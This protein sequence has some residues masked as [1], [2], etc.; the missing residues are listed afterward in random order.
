VRVRRSHETLVVAFHLGRMRLITMLL[1][2]DTDLLYA[3]LSFHSVESTK[4]I[5]RAL[6]HDESLSKS[7]AMQARL[8]VYQEALVLVSVS[9][10]SS[11]QEHL[12]SI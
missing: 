5:R 4:A 2:M 6:P 9:L 11:H 12:P 7:V 3:S 1:D 8:N 10:L